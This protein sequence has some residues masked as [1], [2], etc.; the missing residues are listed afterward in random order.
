M[1]LKDNLDLGHPKKNG[2]LSTGGQHYYYMDTR[3][4]ANFPFSFLKKKKN[5]TDFF[6]LWGVGGS[7]IEKKIPIQHK[8]YHS[9]A[10]P[11]KKHFFL[12]VVDSYGYGN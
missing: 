1:S 6:F 10:P 2:S 7:K 12:R 3:A 11:V 9:G 4:A 8:Y 5:K